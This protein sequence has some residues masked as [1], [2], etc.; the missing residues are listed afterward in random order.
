MNKDAKT[1]PLQLT[2]TGNGWVEARDDVS[3]G[4]FLYGTK[5]V[6]LWRPVWVVEFGEALIIL[7]GHISVERRCGSSWLRIEFG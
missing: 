2:R 4:T 1:D 5:P 6:A 3:C 7:L